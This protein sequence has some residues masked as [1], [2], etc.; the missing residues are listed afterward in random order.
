MLYSLFI[1][2]WQVPQG[3]HEGHIKLLSEAKHTPLVGIRDTEVDE[4]NPYTAKER[5]EKI[6]KLGYKTI[7]LPDIA[8]VV[9]GRGVGYDIRE[10][11]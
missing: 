1:G 2:R 9:Y 7:I 3:L 8:E 4:K 10:V 5:Q 6:E 11:K